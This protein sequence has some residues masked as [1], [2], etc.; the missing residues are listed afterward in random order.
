MLSLTGIRYC[1]GVL[2]TVAARY[3][4]VAAKICAFRIYYNVSQ[5][6]AAENKVA[7]TGISSPPSA[8]GQLFTAIPLIQKQSSPQHD[9]TGT[10]PGDNRSPLTQLV[11]G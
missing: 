7:T 9:Q 1:P 11:A 2:N 8:T 6:A 4:K 3:L 5:P 10:L